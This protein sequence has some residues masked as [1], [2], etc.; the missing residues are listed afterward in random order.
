M[1]ENAEHNYITALFNRYKLLNSK[2]EHHVTAS[3]EIHSKL[4]HITFNEI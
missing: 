3:F 2:H 4:W 1:I